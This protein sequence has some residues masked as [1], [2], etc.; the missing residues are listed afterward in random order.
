MEPTATAMATSKQEGTEV[1][2]FVPF[3]APDGA[4]VVAVVGG[5]PDRWLRS[6]GV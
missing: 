2:K 1:A 4:N 6:T 3:L 5:V